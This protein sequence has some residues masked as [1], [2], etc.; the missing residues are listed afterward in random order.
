MDAFGT[1]Y[2]VHNLPLLVL[3]GLD[4]RDRSQSDASAPKRALLQEGG[5]RLKIDLPPLASPTADALR[6]ALL[7]HDGSEAPWRAPSP[8]SGPSKLFKI[9]TVARVG[10]TPQP[11][12]TVSEP[13]Y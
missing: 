5:F 9:R 8:S 1:D 4:S 10:Q 13:L 12:L 6:N 7:T 3:S 2:V 11:F